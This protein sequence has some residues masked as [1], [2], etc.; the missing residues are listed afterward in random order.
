MK[1]IIIFVFMG[2]FLLA[3]AAPGYADYEGYE[4]KI[5]DGLGTMITS[6]RHLIHSVK[7]EYTA[8]KF[9]PFGVLG[10][11]IKGTFYTGKE[12]SEGLFRVLTFNLGD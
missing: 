7:E 4:T 1:K 5:K 6:P 8:A 2:L 9:K 3:A 11:L 10:G 12:F